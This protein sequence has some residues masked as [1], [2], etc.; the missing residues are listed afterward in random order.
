[1]LGGFNS[2]RSMARLHTAQPLAATKH[3]RRTSLWRQGGTEG[4]K[5]TV[6]HRAMLAIKQASFSARRSR[7]NARRSRRRPVWR[8]ARCSIGPCAKR[9][10]PSSPCPRTSSLLLRAEKLAS[11]PW[12]GSQNPA[13]V[14]IGR[15]TRTGLHLAR[16]R[17]MSG[18]GGS[19]RKSMWYRRFGGKPPQP[20]GIFKVS[21]ADQKDARRWCA[22]TVTAPEREPITVQP[23]SACITSYPCCI[24]VKPC[25]FLAHG[26][27]GP[28]AT[29]ART[30][31]LGGSS[32]TVA[33]H[34]SP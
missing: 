34:A 33:G 9:Q 16:R 18:P 21:S 19:A 24:C 3:A 7:E 13:S 22:S 1:M 4:T 30:R 29:P 11:S 26:K 2:K 20:A 14:G 27:A 31:S 32:A 8:F 17:T 15:P 23:E 25:F 12:T 5:P 28:S 6:R 10:V